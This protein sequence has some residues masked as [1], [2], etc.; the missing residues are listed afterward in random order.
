MNEEE[1]KKLFDE[2]K[3][4]YD[5]KY[6]EFMKTVVNLL[7]SAVHQSLINKTDNLETNDKVATLN[8]ESVNTELA[9][10]E[11]YEMVLEIKAAVTQ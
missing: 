6:N 10:A 5:A 8:T 3:A 1:I 7:D 9:L 2:L 4:E 11:I